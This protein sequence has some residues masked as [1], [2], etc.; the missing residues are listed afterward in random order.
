MASISAKA[1][2]FDAKSPRD[3]EEFVLRTWIR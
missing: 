2:H 1:K 3:M